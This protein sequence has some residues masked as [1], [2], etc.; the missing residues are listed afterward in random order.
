M[1][2]ITSAETTTH[3]SSARPQALYILDSGRGEQCLGFRAGKGIG[4]GEANTNC[5]EKTVLNLALRAVPALLSL[6]LTL[7][8]DNFGLPCDQ[9]SSRSSLK[10]GQLD[11]KWSHL[12]LEP[13]PVTCSGFAKVSRR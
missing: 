10:T 11:H 1:S 8:I 13:L 7:E 5:E 9:S 3:L 2:S 6:V 12:V 4:E